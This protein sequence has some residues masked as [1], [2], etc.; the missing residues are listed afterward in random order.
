MLPFPLLLELL[1]VLAPVCKWCYR[2][3]V[4]VA[5]CCQDA[6]LDNSTVF[7]ELSTNLNPQTK[8]L[9]YLFSTTTYV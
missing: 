2:Y 9:R 8:D 6:S 5:P 7:A 1:V 3:V 4:D